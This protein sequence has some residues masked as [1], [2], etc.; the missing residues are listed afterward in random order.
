V[1][2]KRFAVDRASCG[3]LNAFAVFV[4]CAEITRLPGH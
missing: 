3:R 1:A 2:V 4:F